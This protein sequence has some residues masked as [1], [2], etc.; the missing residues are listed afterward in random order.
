MV[1]YKDDEKEIQLVETRLQTYRVDFFIK[2]KYFNDKK[3]VDLAE[4]MRVIGRLK[5]N[6]LSVFT[7]N[8]LTMRKING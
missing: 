2:G 7:K 6:D 1:C 4:A 5:E 3:C 8:N